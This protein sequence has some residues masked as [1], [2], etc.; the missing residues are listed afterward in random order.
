MRKEDVVIKELFTLDDIKS[1][2]SQITDLGRLVA[3]ELTNVLDSLVSTFRVFTS[4]RLSTTVKRIDKFYQRKAKRDRE[5]EA[6]L[7]QLGAYDFN[8]DLLFISPAAFALDL[9]TTILRSAS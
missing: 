5:V 3:L 9:P 6:S 7:R 1:G 8:P 4:I 2:L